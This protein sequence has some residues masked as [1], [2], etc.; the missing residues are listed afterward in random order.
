ML[1]KTRAIVLRVAPYNDKSSI[2]YMYTEAFGRCSYVMTWPRGRSCKI[3]RSLFMPLSLLEI[4]DTHFPKRDLHRLTEAH[5][6]LPMSR[7]AL[8]PVRNAL[9]LFLAEV[10]YR[11]VRDREPDQGL[12]DY[13]AESV[14]LL[15]RLDQ[16]IANFHIVFLMGLTRFLGI[17]PNLEGYRPGVLFDLREGARAARERGLLQPS[18]D[19]LWEY[20][21]LRLLA[22]GAG[23]D[24]AEDHRLLPVAPAGVPRD[25]LARHFSGL[26]RLN[27]LRAIA[28]LGKCCIFAAE[29]PRAARP[30]GFCLGSST[31][32]TSVS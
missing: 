6:C 27:G 12:F 11:V 8:D 5:A 17:F 13:L 4:E 2:I 30:T 14:A 3:P 7:I 25:P 28:G 15:E 19:P 29:S 24:P 16:G 18:P 26:V 22:P 20:G 31:D 10:L 23:L 21:A 32:R 9:A 1:T